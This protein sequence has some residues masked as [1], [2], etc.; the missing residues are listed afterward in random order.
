MGDGKTMLSIGDRE[1]DI[2]G[3]KAAGLKTCLYNTNNI[4]CGE[5]PDFLINSL[6]E[7]YDIIR[8]S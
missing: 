5:K 2:V 8:I 3:S 7:L 1:C 6:E 4:E